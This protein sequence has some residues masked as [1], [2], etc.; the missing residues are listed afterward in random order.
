MNTVTWACAVIFGHR[1]D[2][3]STAVIIG[4]LCTKST[5]C[6]FSDANMALQLMAAFIATA[7]P[8]SSL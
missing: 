6:S 3:E 5:Q 4:G 7:Q 2:F 1:R 8:E